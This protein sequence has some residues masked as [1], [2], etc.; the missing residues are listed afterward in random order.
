[1]KAD[2]R[3]R[4]DGFTLI[5]LL[6]VI[7]ILA[8]LLA[9]LF[10]LLGKMRESAGWAET[11]S[12]AR[13]LVQAQLAYAA[14]NN[15]Q[16][17]PRAQSSNTMA[18]ME[19]FKYLLN[20]YIKHPYSELGSPLG[21]PPAEVPENGYPVSHKTPGWNGWIDNKYG[22]TDVQP[23][24]F[25]SWAWPDVWWTAGPDQ[26]LM[27]SPSNYLGESVE[28]TPSKTK[29][30]W[31]FEW[32]LPYRYGKGVVAYLDGHAVITPT[33]TYDEWWAWMATKQ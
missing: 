20:T 11:L 25:E 28:N 13:A 21:V 12:N 7:A 30:V 23:I 8:V 16:L 2:N 1:M 15:G 27:G 10:P 31:S 17:P 4:V 33:K 29:L 32:D 22:Y 5:E 14:D 3:R 19:P 9:L 26:R 6:A 24:A 18:K